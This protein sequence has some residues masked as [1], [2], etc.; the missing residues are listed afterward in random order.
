MCLTSKGERHDRG[1]AVDQ[2]GN[3][4]A[5]VVQRRRDK[6]AAQKFFRKLLNGVT[7]GD[8]EQI[9]ELAG[10]PGSGPGRLRVARGE[11]SPPS[12]GGWHQG[13]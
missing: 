10:E 3:V 11:T 8:E 6:Q 7:S 12:P 2:D 4:L 1:R 5:L 13:E 9:P